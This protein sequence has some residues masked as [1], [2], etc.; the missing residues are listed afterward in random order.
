[1]N[2][3]ANILELI[4]TLRVQN[5][6][7]ISIKDLFDLDWVDYKVNW[8]DLYFIENTYERYG[9]NSMW[10]GIGIERSTEELAELTMFRNPEPFNDY[11]IDVLDP[12][13]RIDMNTLL[14]SNQYFEEKIEHECYLVFKKKYI[15]FKVR[16]RVL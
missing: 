7:L 4:Y 8:N 14:K 1:M 9:R 16:T 15:H 3:K 13:I 12:W 10:C 11:R 5:L 6:Y 2:Y